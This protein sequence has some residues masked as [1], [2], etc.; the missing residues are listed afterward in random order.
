[1]P[2]EIEKT[3]RTV[4][5]Q[6]LLR[7]AGR[8]SPAEIAEKY[9]LSAEEVARTITRLLDSR[10]WLSLRQQEMLMLIQLEDLKE[11]VY[12]RLTAMS[13][14]NYG[15]ALNGFIKIFTLVSERI[16]SKKKDVAADIDAIT[17]KHAAIFGN[18]FDR[19]L[20][21]LTEWL[22]EEYPEIDDAEMNKRVGFLLENAAVQ[23]EEQVSDLGL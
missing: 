11:D 5:E 19:V 8:K 13:D 22:V 15:P 6:D 4:L 14:E 1:M 20:N 3:Q 16:D 23:L 2:N 7:Y 21:G 10:D 12:R 18:V 9:G 17:S